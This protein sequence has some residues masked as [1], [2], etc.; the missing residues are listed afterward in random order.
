M[1]IEIEQSNGFDPVVIEHAE[2]LV[3]IRHLKSPGV[4]SVLLT[5]EDAK[6]L[7]RVFRTAE[8]ELRGST[9][10]KTYALNNG[11]L[12]LTINGHLH[13]NSGDWRLYSSGTQFHKQI[14][15]SRHLTEMAKALGA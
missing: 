13:G 3:E 11:D 9:W 8:T 6:T 15:G 14:S 10:T 4:E 1:I 7:G 2:G 12:L 5:S